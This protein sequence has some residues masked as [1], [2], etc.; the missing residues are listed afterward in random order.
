MDAKVKLE[1]LGK[2]FVNL[3]LGIYLGTIY[4]L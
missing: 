2:Y 4:L 1:K 3:F